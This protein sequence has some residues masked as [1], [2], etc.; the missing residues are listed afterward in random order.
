MDAEKM[1]ALRKKLMEAL[2]EKAEGPDGTEKDKCFLKIVTTQE[3]I[4]KELFKIGKD[5]FAF[6]IFNEEK[7]L[8]EMQ[9]FA[10]YL[11]CV[12][13]GIE[14][15]KDMHKIEISDIFD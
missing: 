1:D 2:V 14:T 13:A 15:Y 12:L 5:I 11:E 6:E 3:A 10:E 9:D 8:E 7:G 4:Q